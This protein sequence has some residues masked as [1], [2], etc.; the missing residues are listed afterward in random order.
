MIPVRLTLLWKYIGT[1]ICE[2]HFEIIRSYGDNYFII[3]NLA[4]CLNSSHT[5]SCNT[6][7]FIYS[8]YISF[9]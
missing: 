2:L 8:Y 6:F 9:T 7:I 3:I 1:L 4:V 5:L